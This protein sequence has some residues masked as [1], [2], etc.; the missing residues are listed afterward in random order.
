MSDVACRAQD[1]MTPTPRAAIVVMARYPEAGATKTRLARTLGN[2]AT[3]QLY[4]EFLHDTAFHCSALPYMLHWAY[5]PAHVDYETLVAELAPA[6][7]HKMVCF[8]QQGAD[9]GRR[10]QH[11]FDYTSQQG[12]EHIILIGSDTPHIQPER[13]EE[14]YA[15]LNDSDVVL[16]PAEDGGYYL[17]ALKAPHDVFSGIPM[18]TDSVLRMTIESAQRQGLRIQL[19]EPLFDI[20]EISELKRLTTLLVREPQRAPA[21]A[22]HLQKMEDIPW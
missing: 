3:A 18:S 15:A 8:A 14:A 7:A 22:I 10:L 12:F 2:E 11:A 4:R 17:I 21:T 13:I 6:H 19:L 9:F 16:G 20:D 5:T 1:A